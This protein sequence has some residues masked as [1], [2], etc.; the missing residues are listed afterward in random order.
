MPALLFFDIDGTLITLDEEH[1]MPESTKQALYRVKEKGHKIFINTGRVKTAIDRHLLEFGFDGLICGCGTYIEY[2]GQPVF[3]HT[4]TKEQCIYYA[5]KLREYKMQTVFEGKD[6]LFIDGDYG[7]GG[8]M[9][10]IYNYFSKN[11]EYPIEDSGHPELIYDKFTT[12]IMPESDEEAFCRLF[13]ENFHLIPHGSQVMEVVPN[14]FSKATGIQFLTD[15]LE[16]SLKDCYAFGDSVNDME[17]LQY[18]THSVGM[19]NAVKE[20][21]DVVEYRT[22]EIE[23]DGIEKALIHYGLL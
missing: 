21:L 12:T 3:H 6:R 16:V 18:V 1:R 17:M 22:Q 2:E 11:V 4:L 15:Y 13:S 7:P 19:G 5:G 20:V 9:E 8:F 10:Y 23:K 14:G